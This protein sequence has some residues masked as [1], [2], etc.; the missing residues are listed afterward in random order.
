ME[1]FLKIENG[2]I[3]DVKFRAVGC[4]ASFMAGS[5]LTEMIKG[6]NIKQK[7]AEK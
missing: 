7:H 3:I 1:I 4:A 2:V 5:A 6:M